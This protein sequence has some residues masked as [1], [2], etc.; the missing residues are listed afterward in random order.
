MDVEELYMIGPAVDLK[1]VD[2]IHR[3]RIVAF[4]NHFIINT[5]NFLNQISRAAESKLFVVDDRLKKLEASIVLLEN[6]LNSIPGLN[7]E[8]KASVSDPVKAVN[9][10]VHLTLSTTSEIPTPSISNEA[11]SSSKIT[12]QEAEVVEE[13][14]KSD[15]LGEHLLR[16]V[17]MLHVGVPVPAVKL[18]MVQEGISSEDQEIVLS[19]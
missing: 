4:V 8:N 7:V 1:N 16:F 9:D 2:S 14:K 5:V 10:S 18:K 19:R 6:K 17:K 13:K 11:D 15:E 12:E 3:K